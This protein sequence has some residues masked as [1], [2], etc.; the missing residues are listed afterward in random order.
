MPGDAEDIS[1]VHVETWRS[2]YA[3]ILPDELLTNLS[4]DRRLA[5]W[6][7]E[8]NRPQQPGSGTWVVEVAGDVVGFVSSGPC[9]DEDR[10]GDAHWEVYAI[11]VLAEHSNRGHGRI[12]ANAALDAAP[13]SAEDVSLW[14]LAENVSAIGFYGSLGFAADGTERDES[15]GGQSITELRYAMALPRDT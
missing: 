8:L 12:L 4:V 9:R 15:L 7:Q 13:D 5:Y 14:V 3:G 6:T 10:A 1:R 11:Y 2:A